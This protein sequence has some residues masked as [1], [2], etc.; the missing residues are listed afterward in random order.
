M[1]GLIETRTTEQYGWSVIRDEPSLHVELRGGGESTMLLLH[2]GGVGGWMWN[3]FAGHLTSKYQLLVPD[4]PGH[5]RSAAVP[6]VSHDETLAKLVAIIQEH[7]SEPVVVVGFSLGAQLAVLLAA[8]F[9]ELVRSVAVISA[10]AKPTRFQSATL[11]MLRVA[12][13]L[14]KNERFARLQAKE[15]FIPDSLIDDY[16][17]TSRGISAETLLASVGENM[18]FAVPTRWASFPGR[19]LILAGD[20]ERPV[21]KASASYLASSHARSELEIVEGCGHGIPLQRPEWLANRL[22]AWMR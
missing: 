6:Y 1:S 17:R 7:A 21:M 11:S 16:L 5:D 3:P 20:K 22:E 8:R 12:A 9:P 15:L 10:Q 19:S 2:G 13:P 14:A 18:R 4:L